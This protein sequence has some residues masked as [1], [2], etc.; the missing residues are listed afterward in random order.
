MVFSRD[1]LFQAVVRGD[2]ALDAV[3]GF[4]ALNPRNLQQAGKCV[5]LGF[6]E[7]ILLPLVFMNLREVG[8]DLRRQ[9][10]LIFCFEVKGSH[11]SSSFAFYFIIIAS[12]I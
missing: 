4:G 1:D 12:M 10:L 11:S 5:G 9:E 2:D 7:K 3:G 8:H 6:D